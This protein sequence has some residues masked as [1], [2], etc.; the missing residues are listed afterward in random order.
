MHPS[1]TFSAKLWIYSGEGA[2]YFITLPAEYAAEIKTLVSDWNK[3]GFRSIK[4]K[5]SI[6]NIAWD[7]SIFPDSKSNS[8]LLP[9]KKEI[10][11]KLSIQSGDD[12]KVSIELKDM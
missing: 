10:R 5:V 6:G 4:V 2:W 7:T 12:L 8:Y 1:Y 3:K 9:I 11:T